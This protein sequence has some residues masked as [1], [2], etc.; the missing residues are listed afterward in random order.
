MGERTVSQ[1]EQV[2]DTIVSSHSWLQQR[3]IISS[4]CP[5]A[6]TQRRLRSIR[7]RGDMAADSLTRESGWAELGEVKISWT[8]AMEP[9]DGGTDGTQ[10]IYFQIPS[11]ELC[12][13]GMNEFWCCVLLSVNF[14]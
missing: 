1:S 14:R 11:F 8:N 2:M 6:L 10:G 9:C 7:G 4:R 12:D 13:V 5:I 3:P